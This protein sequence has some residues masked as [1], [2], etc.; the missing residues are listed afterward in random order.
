[1][2]TPNRIFVDQRTGRTPLQVKQDLAES[3][4]SDNYLVNTLLSTEDLQVLN[5]LGMTSDIAK[6]TKDFLNHKLEPK[7]VPPE[8]ELTLEQHIKRAGMLHVLIN[9][10]WDELHTELKLI[11]E[12]L[13][14]KPARA[15]YHG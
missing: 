8:C 14:I 4:A 5:P 9:E 15:Y 2:N 3:L 11:N 10:A 12:E 6:A 1:M 7:Q 13:A